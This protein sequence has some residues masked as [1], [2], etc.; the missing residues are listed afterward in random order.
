MTGR[1]RGRPPGRAAAEPTATAGRRSARVLQTQ[2]HEDQQQQQDPQI[3]PAI[4]AAQTDSMPPPPVPAPAAR[5]GRS[6]EGGRIA[7]VARRSTRRE[8]HRG[9]SISSL[10]SIP[11]SSQ[12]QGSEYCPTKL[13]RP[14]HHSNHRSDPTTPAAYSTSWVGGARHSSMSVAESPGHA[15]ARSKVMRKFLPK[16]KDASEQLVAHI[17]ARDDMER[18]EWDQERLIYKAE[19]RQQRGYYMSD[20]GATVADVVDVTT[21]I[22]VQRPEPLWF[23]VTQIVSMAN[24]AFLLD[25]I[26]LVHPDHKLAVLQIAEAIYPQHCIVQDSAGQSIHDN[27]QIVSQVLDIRTQLLLH[28]LRVKATKPDLFNPYDELLSIFFDENTTTDH[29]KD[30]TRDPHDSEARVKP[31]AG[32]TLAAGTWETELVRNRVSVLC[33]HLVNRSISGAE[34]DLSECDNLYGYEETMKGIRAFL[35]ESFI[36]T[37][38]LLDTSPESQVSEPRLDSQI[39]SQLE[40]ESLSRDEG[41]VLNALQAVSSLE[42]HG[43]AESLSTQDILSHQIQSSAYPPASSVP[44]PSFSYNDP[45]VQPNGA[46]YAQSAAQ[47]TVGR[48]RRAPSGG[49]GGQVPAKKPRGRRKQDAAPPSSAAPASAQS[50]DPTG[51]SQYPPP[52]SATLV[53]TD[54]EAVSQRSREISAANRKAREPQV[55][56]AWVRNDVKQLVRAVDVYKCKWSTIEKEIKLGTIPFEIP[57]DQQAL[58][59]KARLLKQ[60]FLK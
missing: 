26:T 55:R 30:F 48:K 58:R 50:N 15:R 18:E 45:P 25:E 34:L 24:I 49:E 10:N 23:A 54:F 12:E 46:I 52:P 1:G 7:D 37:K 38:A 4:T 17:L 57:R 16:L 53:D 9:E 31:I 28:T 2:Q 8:N 47:T 33:E 56:S 40:A 51:E 44:Y 39:Q 27:E 6:Q 19:F 20:D 35:K 43:D 22:G 5:R 11:T 21:R 42:H 13:L 60:D 59:D 3:D 36:K 29:L 41:A 14:Q 32:I